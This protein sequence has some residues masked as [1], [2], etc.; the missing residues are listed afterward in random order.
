MYPNFKR[1]VTIIPANL[2]TKFCQLERYEVHKQIKTFTKEKGE[3]L[4]MNQK[5]EENRCNIVLEAIRQNNYLFSFQIKNHISQGNEGRTNESLLTPNQNNK[6]INNQQ[7]RSN[8]TKQSINRNRSSNKSMIDQ[9]YNPKISKHFSEF[10]PSSVKT[11]SMFRRQQQNREQTNNFIESRPSVVEF[12][13]IEEYGNKSN[14]EKNNY[15]QKLRTFPR[16]RRAWSPSMLPVDVSSMVRSQILRQA[17]DDFG[18]NCR[19]LV[20]NACFTESYH[21]SSKRTSTVLTLNI[22][23]IDQVMNGREIAIFQYICRERGNSFHFRWPFCNSSFIWAFRGLCV[24]AFFPTMR[25]QL[26]FPQ[27]EEPDTEEFACQSAEN[28]F[29]IFDINNEL[30]LDELANDLM[31]SFQ[32]IN[33]TKKARNK[34][35]FKEIDLKTRLQLH[36]TESGNTIYLTTKI[37]REKY[38]KD[39]DDIEQWPKLTRAYFRYAVLGKAMKTFYQTAFDKQ[40]QNCS[41]NLKAISYTI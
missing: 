20:A 32:R 41:R 5:Q 40:I 7:N 28:N 39:V 27:I 25:E 36:F 11:R 23:N 18:L 38:L 3:V 35:I 14:N 8:T 37:L 22:V 24:E 30:Q 33:T 31:I 17:A 26:G 21:F 1:D 4:V 9:D 15:V 34:L 2:L 6:K 29:S 13:N 16:R 19:S 10:E 12:E